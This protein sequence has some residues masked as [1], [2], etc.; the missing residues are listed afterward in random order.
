MELE[1]KSTMHASTAS[2]NPAF[3]CATGFMRKSQDTLIIYRGLNGVY[4]DTGTTC[5]GR[6]IYQKNDNPE[7]VLWWTNVAGNMSWCIGPWQANMESNNK[8][9]AKNANFGV[10]PAD[11][12]GQWSVFCHESR[13]WMK[14]PAAKISVETLGTCVICFHQSSNHVLIPC[15]HICY[16]TDCLPK[17]D[18]IGS[19]PLCRVEIQSIC[20]VFM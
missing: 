15:G 7:T 11:V 9:W 12:A 8:I 10:H 18:Q 5:H 14:Q 17:T 4:R 19:C 1:C 20:R 6:P 16:C 3:V 13:V 2:A